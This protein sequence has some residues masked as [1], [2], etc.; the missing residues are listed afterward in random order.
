MLFT[1]LGTLLAS[2]SLAETSGNSMNEVNRGIASPQSPLISRGYE[3]G[4][5]VVVFHILDVVCRK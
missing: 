5:I 3:H 2:G 4:G 1:P